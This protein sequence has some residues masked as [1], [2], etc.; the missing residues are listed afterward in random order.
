MT[1][2]VATICRGATRAQS[3][4]VASVT[5]GSTAFS[6]ATAA[7]STRSTPAASAKRL[8]RPVKGA[9]RAEPERRRLRRQRL[10]HRL[11]GRILGHVPGLEPRH[12]D[13]GHPGRRQRRH[14]GRRQ[15]PALLQPQPADAPRMREHRPLGLFR[16]HRSEAHR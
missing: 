12:R 16:R 8:T 4:S 13:L 7:A 5:P 2:T 6:A 14:V 9:D 1:L 11:G 3:G 15:H 10:G